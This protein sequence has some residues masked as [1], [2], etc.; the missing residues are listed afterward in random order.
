MSIG[1]RAVVRTGERR[2]RRPRRLRPD[3]QP[4]DEHGDGLGDGD[5][6]LML[7]CC[8]LA[9]P[10][11][12]RSSLALRLVMG[13]PTDQ[14]A[15]LLLVPTGTVAAR[16]TRAKRKVV[17]AGV[18]ESFKE[19]AYLMRSPANARRLLDAMERLEAGRGVAHDLVETD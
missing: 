15:R 10:R 6:L 12:S 7:L 3:W 2:V 17:L 16:L 13:T 19:P 1:I 5:L 18:W 11:E 14:V 9:L 8:H 4:P